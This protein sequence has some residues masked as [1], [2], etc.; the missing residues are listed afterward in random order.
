MITTLEVRDLFAGIGDKEILKGVNLAIRQ[1]EMHAIMGPNG[2]GKS[3]LSNVIMG[4]PKYTVYSGDVLVNGES[5]L[6]LR[7]DQ[8]AAKGLFLGFQYPVEVP[9]VGLAGFLRN[10]VNAKRKQE[11]KGS[12]LVSEFQQML[13]KQIK[14][15]DMDQSFALRQLNTGFS[16]GEKKRAE[17]LQMAILKPSIAILDEPDSGLDVDALKSVA[18]AIRDLVG[19]ELGVLV[20]THYQRILAHLEPQYVHVLIDGR[21]AKSG[22]SELARLVEEKGYDWVKKE[23]P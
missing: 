5:I 20:I 22:G 12:M 10:L 4:H 19:P 2:S 8:R 6:G 21:V 17:V 14:G 15:L 1:G 13:S 3:T 16:G 18:H 7:P 9:G 11:G 23:L